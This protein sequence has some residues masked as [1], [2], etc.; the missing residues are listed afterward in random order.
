MATTVTKKL[1]KTAIEQTASAATMHSQRKIKSVQVTSAVVKAYSPEHAK[2]VAAALHGVAYEAVQSVVPLR[3]KEVSAP[4]KCQ[5]ADFP[6]QGARK[7]ETEYQIYTYAQRV[8]IGLNKWSYIG[9]EFVKG[10]F[11]SKTEAV[12]EMK[13]LAL[14]HRVPMM[15]QIHKTLKKD[16]NV[17]AIAEPQ[18]KMQDYQ[19]E[20]V[21]GV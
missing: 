9:L 20:F 16:S 4:S 15:V 21:D 6:Q 19:V 17:T 18:M 12:K 11:A 1:A 5:S 3:S 14:K 7:W 10:G 8:P 13:A 2:R